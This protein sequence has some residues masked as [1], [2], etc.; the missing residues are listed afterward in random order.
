MRSLTSDRFRSEI[1]DP[2]L[3]TRQRVAIVTS[4]LLALA[5]AL[6]GAAQSAGPT[7]LLGGDVIFEAPIEWALDQMHRSRDAAASYASLFDDLDLDDA[8]LTIVNLETPIAE[9]VRSREDGYDVPIFAAPSAFLDALAR[10]GVDA[11]TLANNHAYDQGVAGLAA[12]ANSAEAIGVGVLGVGASRERAF[13]ARVLEVRGHRIAIVAASEGV[14]LPARGD[15]ASS[16]R[17]AILDAPLL[18]AAITRARAT[19]ELTIVVLHWTDATARHAL[20]TDDMRTWCERAADAG[21]DLIVA[22]GPHVPG[23]RET[24]VARDGR[25]VTVLYSLGNLIAAMEAGPDEVDLDR[26]SVRDAVL[27]RVMT[28]M[29][30]RGRLAIASV[31]ARGYFIAASSRPVD[32]ERSRFVRPL[33]ID[34]EIARA[35]ESRCD[36]D[37]RARRD[38]LALRGARITRLFDAP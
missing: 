3:V 5:A 34:R 15:E 8:D 1:G 24:I 35:L 38:A 10:A 4:A 2:R 31:R 17:V 21:A 37:C 12:T 7:L 33:S 30:A 14:N 11:V 36:R 20:P 26:A 16:P 23:P 32:G 19:S 6:P 13:D 27:A 18:Q 22:H 25:L 28:R 9:R 29:D